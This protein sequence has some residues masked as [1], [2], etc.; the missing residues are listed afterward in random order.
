LIVIVGA[1]SANE[2]YMRTALDWLR[3]DGVREVFA[4]VESNS[5]T[6]TLQGRPTH[7][8]PLLGPEDV[9]YV[10]GPPGL[11]DAVKSKAAASGTACYADPFL[12]GSEKAS[13][14]DLI[15]RMFQWRRDHHGRTIKSAPRRHSMFR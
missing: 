12:P 9:V 4:V 1:R 7:Y 8:L 11:V 3:D 6:S 14:L 15:V 10:A 13:F 5:E 2:L